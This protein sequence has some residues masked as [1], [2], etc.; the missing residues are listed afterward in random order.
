VHRATALVAAL[1]AAACPAS[2]RAADSAWELEAELGSGLDTNPD[3]LEGP[4]ARSGGFTSLRVRGKARSSG[5]RLGLSAALTEA[6]RLYPGFSDATAVASKLDA[7]AR[8]ALSPRLSAGAAVL[9]S[10]LTESGGRLDQD[11]LHAEASLAWAGGRWGASLS[12]GWT[13]FAPRP[14]PVRAFLASGPEARLRTWWAPARGHVLAAGYSWWSAGYPRW[15]VA[16]G[17]RDDRTQTVWAEYAHRGSF[18]AALG[19]AYSWNTST[20]AGGAFQRHRVTGRAAAFLPL[21]FSLAA[22]ASLEWAHYPEPL[23]VAEE[24]LLAQGQET[25]DALE[26]RLTRPVGGSVDVGL[27]LALYGGEAVAGGAAPGFSRTVLSA[28]VGWRGAWPD[29]P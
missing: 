12:G 1:L 28:V 17:G 29:E 21:R 26:V 13:L 9:A 25:Q 7:S 27:S 16:P 10:D 18:L 5:E 24:L 22:R 8:L 20:A 23:F 4:G 14:Q 15:D 3:R 6:G 2:S 19:Y 11:A